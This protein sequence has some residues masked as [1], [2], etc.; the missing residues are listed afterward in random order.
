MSLHESVVQ[1]DDILNRNIHTIHGKMHAMDEKMHAMEDR[2]IAEIV[3]P[4]LKPLHE[5]EYANRDLIT[6]T[7]AYYHDQITQLQEYCQGLMQRVQQLEEF[8]H[9]EQD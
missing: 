5:N 3:H 8:E 6:R 1:L 2:G 4:M 7:D 9:R